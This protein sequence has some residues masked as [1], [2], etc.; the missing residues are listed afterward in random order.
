MFKSHLVSTL[1]PHAATEP[2]VNM[3]QLTAAEPRWREE[4]FQITPQRKPVT[5]DTRNATRP[6]TT[7][8]RITQMPLQRIPVMVRSSNQRPVEAGEGHQS[9][10]WRLSDPGA[11]Q[12]SH[13]EDQ[14][15][16]AHGIGP[17]G[18][19]PGMGT[20][21]DV[22]VADPTAKRTGLSVG[23]LV[24]LGV[25]AGLAYVMLKGR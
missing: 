20:L 19:M 1:D 13:L 22:D 9:E 5:L 21:Q 6:V 4:S 3:D 11:L 2:S 15:M 16:V 17:G 8:S 25:M 23:M 7:K 14:A 24:G 10:S 12:H 18:W